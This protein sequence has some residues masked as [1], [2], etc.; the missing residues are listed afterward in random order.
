M[1]HMIFASKVSSVCA[2]C[3]DNTSLRVN[4]GQTVRLA[5]PVLDT[6]TGPVFRQCPDDS[7]LRP[8][9]VGGGGGGGGG[10]SGGAQLSK[11]AAQEVRAKEDLQRTKP[12]E[13]AD[14][15]HRDHSDETD[16]PQSYP[17]A[18][19]IPRTTRAARVRL[20]GLPRCLRAGIVSRRG[21]VWNP[22][23]SKVAKMQRKTVGAFCAVH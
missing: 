5:L 3:T 11:L 9:L 16:A 15:V 17:R 20:R 21:G 10:G 4:E 22:E 12:A 18:A 6:G 23:M 13:H 19:R 8:V 14:D 2:V 7:E 1:R